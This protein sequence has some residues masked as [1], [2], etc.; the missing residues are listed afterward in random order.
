MGINGARIH[1]KKNM[2]SCFAIFLELYFCS[3]WNEKQKVKVLNFEVV[4]LANGLLSID[5]YPSKY[6][7][8]SFQMLVTQ[9][10]LKYKLSKLHICTYNCVSILICHFPI[11]PSPMWV[12]AIAYVGSFSKFPDKF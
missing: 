10:I 11:N 2:L 7:E 9:F 6:T 4:V 3:C 1:A 12:F 5:T 8:F